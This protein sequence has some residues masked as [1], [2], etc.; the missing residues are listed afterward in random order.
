MQAA[1]KLFGAAAK[2]MIAKLSS[3]QMEQIMARY[4][5]EIWRPPLFPPQLNSNALTIATPRR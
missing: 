1:L 4:G 5:I 3:A 2:G